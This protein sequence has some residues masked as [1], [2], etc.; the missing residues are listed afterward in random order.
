[1]SSLASHDSSQALDVILDVEV[2]PAVEL[3]GSAAVRR[4]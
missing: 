1:M 2:D 3:D 4:R